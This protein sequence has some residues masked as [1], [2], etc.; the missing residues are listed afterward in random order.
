MTR[1]QRQ[2]LVAEFIGVTSRQCHCR[3][4]IANK[5]WLSQ[6][7]KTAKTAVLISVTSLQEEI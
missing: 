7:N 3:F 1:Q 5:N 2:L 4:I 6:S